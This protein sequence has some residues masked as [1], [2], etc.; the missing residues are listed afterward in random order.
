[1][2]R[3]SWRS[4]ARRSATR[5]TDPFRIRFRST[6]LPSCVTMARTRGRKRNCSGRA[7]FLGR[8][9]CSARNHSGE[10]GRSAEDVG[11]EVAEGRERGKNNELTHFIPLFERHYCHC[12]HDS[13]AAWQRQGVRVDK[14]K[15]ALRLAKI[16][17][18]LQKKNNLFAKS[19]T[20]LLRA[21]AA[22][23]AI[24]FISTRTGQRA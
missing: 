13:M 4:T 8:R 22:L 16:C 9:A 12:S 1:M 10:R 14:T 2:R 20:C 18:H 7:F 19:V 3:R 11:G 24:F 21:S 15:I 23:R 5:P 6:S 17:L